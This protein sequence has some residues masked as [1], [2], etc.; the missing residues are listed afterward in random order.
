MLRVAASRARSMR[1]TLVIAARHK[2]QARSY[3]SPKPPKLASATLPRSRLGFVAG[4]RALQKS[5]LDVDDRPTLTELLPPDASVID[6]EKEDIKHLPRFDAAA[7][8]EVVL[9]ATETGFDLGVRKLRKALEKGASTVTIQNRQLNALGFD[10]ERKPTFKKG[11]ADQPVAVI[12]LATH[13]VVVLFLL[14]NTKSMPASLQ[15]LLEDPCV[16]K[17][18]VALNEDTNALTRHTPGLTVR[19]L[20]DLAPLAE[21]VFPS[22]T[23]RGLRGLC[24]SLGGQRL[25]KKQSMSPWGSKKYSNAMI[26]YAANDALAGLFCFG[27]ILGHDRSVKSA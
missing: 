18:G 16:L 24:A 17:V 1:R 5:L 12:Q 22:L 10:T 2:P 26:Q 20:V 23:R 21:A 4:L 3:S 19:G 14:K 25:S 6:I 15:N 27:R 9:C 7:K 11:A 13:D 8:A